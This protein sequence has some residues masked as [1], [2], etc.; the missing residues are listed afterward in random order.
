[1]RYL[2]S[3]GNLVI[4]GT[5]A[6]ALARLSMEGEPTLLA[7]NIEPTAQGL[8]A[9]VSTA[10]ALRRLPEDAATSACLTR[11]FDELG[12]PFTVK[13]PSAGARFGMFGV[14]ACFNQLL[15]AEARRT[16]HY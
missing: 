3:R 11:M 12:A 8:T 9:L 5:P 14:G 6:C 7:H 13:G 16:E 10:E 2:N 1:V 15:V 4:A